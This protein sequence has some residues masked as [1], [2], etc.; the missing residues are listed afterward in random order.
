[1]TPDEIENGYE[2]NMGK[3]ISETFFQNGINLNYVSAVLVKN[4]GPFS[5]GENSL[6]AVYN[7]IVL[8]ECANMA[9]I[10]NQICIEINSIN[11]NLLDKHFM[12]KHGEN[13][14]YVRG[15]I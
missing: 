9:F 14:Y 11:F 13:A 8:E 7:A 15:K 3:V 2:R 5:W 1:M 12:R 4:H 6:D 10:C